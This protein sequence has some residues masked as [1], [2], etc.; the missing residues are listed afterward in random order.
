MAAGQR[1][2]RGVPPARRGPWGA[3]LV[4]HPVQ[5][6]GPCGPNG[7]VHHQDQPR[8]TPWTPVGAPRPCERRTATTSDCGTACERR[9]RCGGP[10]RQ[11]SLVLN[12]P[13]QAPGGPLLP[14]HPLRGRPE[15]S[16]TRRF[17]DVRIGQV[18]QVRHPGESLDRRALTS[19]LV[20]GRWQRS[21]GRDVGFEDLIERRRA[22]ERSPELPPGGGPWRG[23]GVVH[24]PIVRPDGAL[25]P[26][27]VLGVLADSSCTS[28][29]TLAR[30]TR[31]TAG[32]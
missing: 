32:R 15:R 4:L 14:P 9:P 21:G 25:L 30:A 7:P 18:R 13:D 10:A 19:A 3:T 24:P 23:C 16:A 5:T 17:P 28:T 6:P 20:I 31:W 29:A 27:P 2:R 12:G 22:I 11:I 8:N 1:G 26:E